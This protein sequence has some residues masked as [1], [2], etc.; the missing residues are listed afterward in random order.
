MGFYPYSTME[1]SIR[2]ET[3]DNETEKLDVGFVHGFVLLHRMPIQP[4]QY[5]VSW[6]VESGSTGKER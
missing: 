2:H 1:F 3:K 6:H 5:K 4:S